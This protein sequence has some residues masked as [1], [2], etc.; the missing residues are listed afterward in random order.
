MTKQITVLAAVS[1]QQL[2]SSGCDAECVC[3][4]IGEAKR[5]A[6]Y[7]L[8][9]EYMRACESTVMLNYAEIR[10]NGKVEYDFYGR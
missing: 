10:V 9:E 5:R 4:T 1:K 6:K 8:S 2:D 7:Y 3:E